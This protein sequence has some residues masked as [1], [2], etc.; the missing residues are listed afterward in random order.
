MGLC[1]SS[2]FSFQRLRSVRV[3]S[4]VHSGEPPKSVALLH[5]T[6]RGRFGVI[7]SP[8]LGLP[9]RE[10]LFCCDSH[11]T[12]IINDAQTEDKTKL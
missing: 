9:F 1:R 11:Y 4:A 12:R 3:V 10:P 7:L 2:L 5:V 8:P 6:L